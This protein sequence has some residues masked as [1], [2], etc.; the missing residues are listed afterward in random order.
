MLRGDDDEEAYRVPAL[1]LTGVFSDARVLI[2]L[3]VWFGMNIIFGLGS[4]PAY[5]RRS[6]GGVASA[7]RRLSR[8]FVSFFMVRPAVDAAK[9][10]WCNAALVITI[11]LDGTGEAAESFS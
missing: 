5:R 10:R 9:R 11:A 8:R 3:A 1:S 4:L 7:Y 2:F 6:A